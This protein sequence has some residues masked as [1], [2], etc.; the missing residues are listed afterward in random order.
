M[1]HPVYFDVNGQ[2]T[3]IGTAHADKDGGFVLVLGGTLGIGP[4]EGPARASGASSGG[5]GGSGA[6]FPPY[7]RSKGRPIHGASL[8]ELEYYAGNA[9]KSIA[10]PEKARWRAKEEALLA[11][12]EAEIVRQGGGAGSYMPPEPNSGRGPDDDGDLIPF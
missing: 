7:G 3:H 8:S 9:R 10:D 5:G 6:V 12:L 1:T 2:K 11:E 4:S